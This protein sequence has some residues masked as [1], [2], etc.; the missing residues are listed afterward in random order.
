MFI[1]C[2]GND[3][4][5]LRNIQRLDPETAEEAEQTMI[6]FAEIEAQAAESAGGID[7]LR[8]RM[9]A[10]KSADELRS[11]PADRYFSEMSFRIF[12]AGLNTAMVKGKWPAFETAFLGFVPQKVAFMNEDDVAGLMANDAIIRHLGKIRATVHNAAALIE[13][14]KQE[15]SFGNYI[16]SWPDSDLIG[17]Y[18]DITARFKQLGG[19]SGPYFLRMMGRDGFILTPDVVRAL[20]KIGVG[21]G[22]FTSKKDRAAVQAAFDRWHQESGRPYAHI[23]RTLS[24][25]PG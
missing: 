13:V 9:P 12:A 18:A 6:S 19:N 25:W 3:I 10:L 23:S 17:L 16:A 4:D 24:I 14:E 15:G 5:S 22:K 1:R 8:A 20:T 21:E 11:T 2:A 7:A